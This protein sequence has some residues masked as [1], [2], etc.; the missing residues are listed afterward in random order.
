MNAEANCDLDVRVTPRSSRND[1]EVTTEGGL[2][3]WLT[4]AP[5]D[6]QANE[7]ARK[8]LAARLGLSPSAISLV[9]GLRSRQKRFRVAGIGPS[10][11][12][13]RLARK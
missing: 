13:D 5:T 10:E 4:A 3:M 7:A 6:G 9:A 2:R 12:I 8:L 1:I 11:A